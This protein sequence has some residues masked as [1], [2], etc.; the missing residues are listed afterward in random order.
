MFSYEAS[1]LK[2]LVV[3]SLPCP[4]YTFNTVSFKPTIREQPMIVF[5]LL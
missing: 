2:L 1:K 5:R 4:F 3:T